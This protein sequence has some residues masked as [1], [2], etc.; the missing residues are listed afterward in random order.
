MNLLKITVVAALLSVSAYAGDAAKGKAIYKKVNCALCHNA[1]GMGKAKDGKLA[2]VKGP[3]IAGLDAAYII[4]Q[5]T[6]IKS[7]KRKTKNTSMMW[8]KIRGL[9]DQ[10]IKDV[11]AYVTTMSKDKFKGMNQK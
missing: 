9:S 3:R 7:K 8:T 5:V 10:D 2:I 11:A 1:D 4:E 6:A